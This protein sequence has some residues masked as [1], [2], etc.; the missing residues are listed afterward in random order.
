MKILKDIISS[1]KKRT[2]LIKE[3][4]ENIWNGPGYSED[5]EVNEI[6]SEL[7][8]DLDFYEPNEALRMED[9]SYYGEERLTREVRTA[10]QKL[11]KHKNILT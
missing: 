6:L 5:E 7:A 2:Q 9:L 4:Q 11:A 8:Y 1:S 10:L 3:F